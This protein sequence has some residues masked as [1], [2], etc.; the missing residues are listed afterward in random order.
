MTETKM[1][2]LQG[3]PIWFDLA[4]PDPTSAKSFYS[5]LFGWEWADVPMSGGSIY[6]MAIEH[7]AN[8]VGL[9]EESAVDFPEGS[10][11]VWRNQIYVSDAEES[12]RRI[13]ASGGSVLSGPSDA[14]GWGVTARVT[15][16]EGAV[17]GLWQSL[18]GHGAEVFA[19]PGAVCWVEYHTHDLTVAKEF[20]S[21]VFGCEFEEFKVPMDGGSGG[22]FSLTMVDLDGGQ[23]HC[24]FAE[25]SD[26][27]APASWATY[28]MVEDIRA[29]IAKAE[30]LGAESVGDVITVPP[31]S[32]AAMRDPQGMGFS[33]WQS[34]W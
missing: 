21:A 10:A 5:G 30:A 18:R 27:S 2:Q 12:C 28:F 26:K 8:V 23:K 20:Y 15:T 9:H 17:F 6:S 19:A 34:A 24:A 25:L 3:N 33:L 13:E 14:D 31:G 4:T 29:A 11:R 22:E 32:L 1:S 16:H 7:D